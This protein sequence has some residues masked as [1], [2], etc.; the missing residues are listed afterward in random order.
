MTSPLLPWVFLKST[1]ESE[2]NKTAIVGTN[3]KLRRFCVAVFAVE[4]Q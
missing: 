2:I 1:S 4:K 3:A